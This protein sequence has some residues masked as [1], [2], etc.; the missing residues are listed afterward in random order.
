M[1]NQIKAYFFG[2]PGSGF[3]SYPL[4]QY[5]KFEKYDSSSFDNGNRYSK[6][7]VKE[8]A[9]IITHVEY[10]IFGKGDFGNIRSG[11]NF[12]V[13]LEISNGF[14]PEEFHDEVFSF[15]LGFFYKGIIEEVELIER[16]SDDSLHYKITSF[17]E[18]SEIFKNIRDILIQRFE[19]KFSSKLISIPVSLIGS[20]FELD[21]NVKER[22][23][24]EVEEKKRLAEQ[25][26]SKDEQNRIKSKNTINK[27]KIIP[28]S[29]IENEAWEEKF[30]KLKTNLKRSQILQYFL[31]GVL[32]ILIGVTFFAINE[33]NT[34]KKGLVELDNNLTRL[35]KELFDTKLLSYR[36]DKTTKVV[37]K[38]GKNQFFLKSEAFL[39]HL[40]STKIT[41]SSAASFFKEI[42]KYLN[43][44]SQNF[45]LLDLSETQIEN[46]LKL[47][48]P[49]DLP[50]ILERFENLE[51]PIIINSKKN[52]DII[53]SELLIHQKL[54]Q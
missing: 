51:E 29:P 50:R 6:I 2:S 19:N 54:P 18:N 28:T 47:F 21:P 10:G 36:D 17:K 26:K 53:P 11:R 22:K 33:T 25:L 46:Q 13:C 48:N 3:T 27:D 43:T 35:E 9:S 49:N 42:A 39:V 24:R 30:K 7:V 23:K 15:I 8:G 40:D 45:S 12:G 38:N 52:K 44:N 20:S 16:K 5:K 31:L 1:V 37:Y 4:D 41:F 14:I 34:T 32:I